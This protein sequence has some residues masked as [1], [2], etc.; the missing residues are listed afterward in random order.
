V[1]H[2][3][4]DEEHSNVFATWRDLGGTERD[5]PDGE[6]EWALLRASDELVELEPTRI[7]D[8]GDDGL[9][10]L[11]FRLPQPGISYLA[12]TPG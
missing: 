1:R 9:L 12:V 6:D 8:I 10:K 4:V 2:W 7:V 11:T 3:R 5:W